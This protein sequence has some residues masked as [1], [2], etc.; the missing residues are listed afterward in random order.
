MW[1][2][3]FKGIPFLA[4]DFPGRKH[5]SLRRGAVW[6]RSEIH[7][8][9]LKSGQF[10]RLFVSFTAGLSPRVGTEGGLLKNLKQQKVKTQ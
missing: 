2:G 5:Y 1:N 3:R 8:T 10:F 7:V 6:E 4:L 9:L